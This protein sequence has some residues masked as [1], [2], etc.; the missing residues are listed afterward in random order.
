MLIALLSTLMLR[1]AG[2]IQRRAVIATTKAQIAA[3][4][5]AIEAYKSDWGYY[6]VTTA[7]RIS[8]QGGAEATNNFLLY[9]ALTGA[10]GKMYSI[11]KSQLRF[12]TVYRV[13]NWF[14]AWG[15][16]YNY[17]NSPRTAYA[18]S[19]NVYSLSWGTN[20]AYTVG[21][22]VNTSSYD[23]FSYGPDHITYVN[24]AST[25]W[26]RFAWPNGNP[27]GN[28]ASANDDIANWKQ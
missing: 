8:N 12:N 6:P 4:A 18:V 23:L 26:Y 25:N 14:D 16:P 15:E 5:V 3:L 11:P 22:Q 7:Q 28:P 27:W 10:G 2:Y 21:G 17:Y 13:M 9:R 1:T 20:T 19:N 24:G